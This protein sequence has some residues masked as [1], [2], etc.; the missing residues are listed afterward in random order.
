[1]FKQSFQ[2]PILWLKGDISLNYHLVLT[3]R[4]N[5]NCQYCHGGEVT[6]PGTD[7]QYEIEDLA[8]FLSKDNDIQLMFYGGEPTL[9][10]PLI[11]QLMDKFT[12]ARFMLQTNALL[13]N[14]IPFDYVTRFHSILVS[15][16]GSEDVTDS[17]RSKGVYGKV[18]SNVRWLRENGYKGDIVARMAVCQES[19]VYRDV[20]HL[21]DIK[22]PSFDHV[23]WQLNVI[24]SA[25]GN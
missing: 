4:C 20:R 8:S 1:M 12:N 9:W 11:K 10:I 5:L 18:I 17:Y 6:G 22:D 13:L 2:S 19:D 7:I 14:R 24:W 3:R 25:E 23:H 21:L 16:D 15:I